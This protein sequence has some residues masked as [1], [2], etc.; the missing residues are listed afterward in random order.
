MKGNEIPKR[1]INNTTPIF[2]R[3]GLK[4]YI[5]KSDAKHIHFFI[6]KVSN[7]KNN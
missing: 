6:K 7:P 4:K 3:L 2:E 1:H 5:G